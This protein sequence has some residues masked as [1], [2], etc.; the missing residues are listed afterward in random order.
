MSLLLDRSSLKSIIDFIIEVYHAPLRENI[1]AI[2]RETREMVVLYKGKYPEL[3]ELLQL[4]L[5]FREDI[6]VHINTEEKDFFPI[7]K[8]MEKTSNWN[9]FFSNCDIEK[10]EKTITKLE[11]EHELID[12]YIVKLSK[13]FE[14][15]EILKDKNSFLYDHFYGYYIWLINETWNHTEIE[16]T[17]LH[18]LAREVFEG[19]CNK[20]I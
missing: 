13:I 20:K 17:V 8:E 10:F 1:N 14:N 3:E 7:L 9:W 4:F 18:P 2:E 5:T 16:N 19:I 12:E 11:K 6:S 15:I